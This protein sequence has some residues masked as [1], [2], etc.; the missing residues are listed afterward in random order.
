MVVIVRSHKSLGDGLA[1][2]S[3]DLGDVLAG[4]SILVL[5]FDFIDQVSAD[6]L[7]LQGVHQ[8]DLD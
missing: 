5:D 1:G 2:G 4:K 6:L 3:P 8:V 7:L